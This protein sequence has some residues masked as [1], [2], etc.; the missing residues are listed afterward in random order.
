MTLTIPPALALV[1][2]M[3]FPTGAAAQ[4]KLP[5]GPGDNPYMTY[6]DPKDWLVEGR[7]IIFPDKRVNAVS[8]GG[9]GFEAFQLA[10]PFVEASAHAWSDP[11]GKEF[12]AVWAAGAGVMTVRAATVPGSLAPY[13]ILTAAEPILATETIQFSIDNVLI[14][15]ETEFDQKAA[16]DLPWP[17]QFPSDATPWLTRDPVYDRDSEEGGDLVAK[18]LNEWTGDNDPRQLPPV[19]LAKFLTAKVLEHVRTNVNNAKPPLAVPTGI[20]LGL[21]RPNLTYNG[22]T[23]VVTRGMAGG[24]LVKNAADIVID[25]VGS[26]HDLTNLLT[27]MLRRVGIPARTVIGVDKRE[28]GINNRYKSWVEFAMIAPDVDRVIWIPVDVMD[29]KG[30]GRNSR[31]WQQDWDGF[32]TTDELR[33]TVPIAFHFHPP[34][35]YRSYVLPALF[36]IQHDTELPAIGLQAFTYDVNSVPNRGGN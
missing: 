36:G 28:T 26:E 6:S 13:A 9:E 24:L 18:L 5:P 10:I 11:D 27:A 15:C 25:P 29:L 4:K 7:Y 34:A 21:N 12:P 22:R 35:N 33:E 16:W 32:G 20:R 1:G 3:L 23:V 2:L 14:T 17:A 8:I 31:N 30:S 19:Q